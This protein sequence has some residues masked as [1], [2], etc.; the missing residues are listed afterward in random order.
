[1]EVVYFSI[2]QICDDA[3]SH[4]GSAMQDEDV[5]RKE[6]LAELEV[7]RRRI[8]E[9]E[10]QEARTERWVGLVQRVN[11]LKENLLTHGSLDEKLKRIG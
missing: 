1:M 2:L 3:V 11:A 8:A 10:V 9:F 6:F 5:I 4:G 7:L